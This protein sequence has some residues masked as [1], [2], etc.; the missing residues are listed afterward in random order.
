M[1]YEDF[2]KESGVFISLPFF[3]RIAADS[4]DC[5]DEL[6]INGFFRDYGDDI[7]TVESIKIVRTDSIF[8]GINEK[9]SVMDLLISLSSTCDRVFINYA[10]AVSTLKASNDEMDKSKAVIAAAN[11]RIDEMDEKIRQLDRRARTLE[12]I[13]RANEQPDPMKKYRNLPS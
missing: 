11:A 7:I 5:S 6:F 2:L 9:P 13:L 4:G 10:R 1:K 8:S 3:R 12:A